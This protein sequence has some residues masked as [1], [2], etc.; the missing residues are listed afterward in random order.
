MGENK[1]NKHEQSLGLTKSRRRYCNTTCICG[2]SLA[3]VTSVNST[4]N[5]N[6]DI[7]S[8]SSSPWLDP[9]FSAT[10]SGVR[11]WLPLSVVP[12]QLSL[13]SSRQPPLSSFF[14]STLLRI[15]LPLPDTARFQVQ[16][17]FVWFRA[18]TGKGIACLAG[19]PHSA[20]LLLSL[21]CYTLPLICTLYHWVLSKEESSTSFCVF[22]VTRPGIKP[23]SPGAL[24]NILTIMP[25]RLQT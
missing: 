16:E 10:V 17:Y 9:L 21:D 12:R 15:P 8:G 11:C 4:S 20:T 24:A 25:N 3:W 22:C 18:N 1:T 14:H 23:R 2:L 5:S 13:L 19:L 7:L 6:A